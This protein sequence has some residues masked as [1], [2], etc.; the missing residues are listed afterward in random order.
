M[1]IFGQSY[2]QSE[3]I[4]VPIKMQGGD[5]LN[6]QFRP[7]WSMTMDGD[8][9]IDGTFNK[10]FLEIPIPDSLI[11]LTI[12][13]GLVQKFYNEYTP[14]R[15]KE[16]TE[17]T[18]HFKQTIRGATPRFFRKDIMTLNTSVKDSLE[19]F[20]SYLEKDQRVVGYEVSVYQVDKLRW[21]EKRQL[22]R[23]HARIDEYMGDKTKLVFTGEPYSCSDVD[24]FNFQTEVT[25]EFIN[26]Q[27]TTRMR[28]LAQNYSLVIVVVRK[29]SDS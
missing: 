23:L 6:T 4:V 19:W 21:A 22:R 14:E 18:V 12:S 17:I 28:K 1:L 13:K 20:R 2:A 7:I 11:Q 29:W 16:L 8:S 9:V 15:L 10:P 24:S 27:N 25:Q 3:S 26:S 5:S